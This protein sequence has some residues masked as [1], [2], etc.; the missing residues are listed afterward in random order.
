MSFIGAVLEGRLL[1]KNMNSLIILSITASIMILTMIS[2][3]AINRGEK[4]LKF[5]N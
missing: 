3:G 4:R 1:E 5:K 2:M